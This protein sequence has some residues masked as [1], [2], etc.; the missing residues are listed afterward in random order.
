MFLINVTLMLC[1][2]SIFDKTFRKSNDLLSKNNKNKKNFKHRKSFWKFLEA[3]ILRAI[4]TIFFAY[5]LV[6]E[7]EKFVYFA[8]GVLIILGS[9]ALLYLL[10]IEVPLTSLLTCLLA[11]STATSA[12]NRVPS[13]KKGLLI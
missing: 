9:K 4:L 1:F 2:V 11:N 3:K 7:L 10:T 8:C 5:S 12:L 13:L 6:K